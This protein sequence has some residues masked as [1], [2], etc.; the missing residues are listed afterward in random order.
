MTKRES[1]ESVRNWIE[2]VQQSAPD[3]SFGMVVGT[4]LD[5]VKEDET[6]R[7]VTSDEGMALA[8]EYG[9]KFAE[10]SSKSGHGLNSLFLTTA[11]YVILNKKKEIDDIERQRQLTQEKVEFMM[12]SETKNKTDD[13]VDLDKARTQSNIKIKKKCCSFYI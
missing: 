1:F 7:D 11:S 12:T 10:V 2:N 4:K 8:E 3:N 5:L 6:L 9:I 13:K